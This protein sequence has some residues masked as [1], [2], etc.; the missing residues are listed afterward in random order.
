MGAIKQAA[1]TNW[2]KIVITG[3]LTAAGAGLWQGGS[4]MVG[5]LYDLNSNQAQILQR[6]DDI[7]KNEEE[8]IA[9]WKDSLEQKQQIAVLKEKVS[10][11]EH[12]ARFAKSFSPKPS[13][14]GDTFTAPVVSL[15]AIEN[16]RLE[17]RS[18]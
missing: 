1:S 7:E 11:L 13:A 12:V 3:F 5:F 4:A 16:H 17:Q 15:E 14:W 6:L 8:L 10:N 18:E 2:G 9:L